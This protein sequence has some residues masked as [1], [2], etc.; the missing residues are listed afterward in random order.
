MIVK[1]IQ[2][3]FKSIFSNKMRS[4]LTV[5]GVI[6]G[7][8]SVV[9]LITIGQGATD[10][11]RGQIEGM[12]TNLIYVNI[13]TAQYNPLTLQS[14]QDLTDSDVIADAA[15]AVNASR[16]SVKADEF[17][18]D[19][20]SIVG[21]TPEHKT[22][23]NQELMYGRYLAKPDI[24]N[25]SFVAVV[26][27]TVAD[28]LFG[29]HDIV[30]ETITVDGY[31]YTVVGVLEEKGMSLAGSDD[32]TVFIPFTLANRIYK[33]PRINAFYVSAKNPESVDAAQTELEAYLNNLFPDNG[34]NTTRERTEHEQF[35]GAFFGGDNSNFMVM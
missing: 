6:I 31:I 28:K 34:K 30:G 7:I 13:F 11:V 26:G 33:Q 19:G 12:G 29:T 24:D 27:V 23:R 21:T 16:I 9:V 20:A 35:E 25:R 15:P 4:F 32:T 14:L 8:V 10:S 3:A 2:M 18:Y 5:L 17:S 22:I 1:S